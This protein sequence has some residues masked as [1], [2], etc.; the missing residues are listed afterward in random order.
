MDALVP[1]ADA[2]RIRLLPLSQMGREAMTEPNTAAPGTCPR[3][4]ERW[5][6]HGGVE[7]PICH[8]SRAAHSPPFCHVQGCRGRWQPDVPH[9]HEGAGEP[10]LG[11]FSRSQIE[12][13]TREG[14][15]GE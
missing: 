15:R 1:Q 9:N 4:G 6:A 5:T 14:S 12:A 7:E 10:Y 13:L 8:D 2:T 3:C 11:G